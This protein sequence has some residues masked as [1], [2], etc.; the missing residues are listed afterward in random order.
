VDSTAIVT[1]VQWSVYSLR[2]TN[3]AEGRDTPW[4]DFPTLVPPH[5]T[6][7]ILITIHHPAYCSTIPARQLRGTAQATYDGMLTVH[8]QSLL[9]SHTTVI[10]TGFGEDKIGVC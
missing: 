4:H 1:R 10:D 7:R 9:H 3:N 2:G 8:W 6:I 5:T